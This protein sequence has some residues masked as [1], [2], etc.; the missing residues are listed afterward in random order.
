MIEV[1]ERAGLDHFGLRFSSLQHIVEQS[2]G[3]RR[4]LVVGLGM[5]A[6]RVG[7]R[8]SRVGRCC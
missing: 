7:R 1:R 5:V 4:W 3:A 2:L 8:W 6:V